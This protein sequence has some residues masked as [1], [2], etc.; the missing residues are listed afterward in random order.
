M[1]KPETKLK[2]KVLADLKGLGAWAEKIQQVGKVGTPDILACY[3]GVFIAL[4]LKSKEEEAPSKAQVIKLRKIKRAGGYAA[5]VTPKNWPDI[6][7]EIATLAF[8]LS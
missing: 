1:K 4:E 5:I 2:E 6:R 7:K 3:R 8:V